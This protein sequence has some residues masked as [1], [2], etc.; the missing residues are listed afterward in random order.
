MVTTIS[1]WFIGLT[2]KNSQSIKKNDTLQKNDTWLSAV[3]RER[4]TD[5]KKNY[6]YVQKPAQ[7]RVNLS[8]DQ[9]P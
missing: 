8:F 6:M 3:R 9:H 1:I 5:Q 7:L 4:T 2:P